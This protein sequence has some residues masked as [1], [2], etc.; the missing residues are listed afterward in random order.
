MAALESFNTKYYT[1]SDKW[2]HANMAI[3]GIM[4]YKQEPGESAEVETT[5]QRVLYGTK[6][7]FEDNSVDVVVIPTGV[8]MTYLSEVADVPTK[9]AH[10]MMYL[11]NEIHRILKPNGKLLTSNMVFLLGSMEKAL[12]ASKFGADDIGLLLNN[13][14]D[15]NSKPANPED[16]NFVT[17]GKWLWWSYIP[18]KITI[19]TKKVAIAEAINLENA[20]GAGAGAGVVSPIAPADSGAIDDTSSPDAAIFCDEEDSKIQYWFPE[21]RH[22]RLVE[23]LIAVTLL[24]WVGYVILT[25]QCLRYLELPYFLPYDEQMAALFISNANIV[26]F[27]LYIICA[28]M[29][30]VART[31]ESQVRKLG[32]GTTSAEITA[33]LCARVRSAYYDEMFDVAL[34]LTLNSGLGWLPYFLFDMLLVKAFGV[35]DKTVTNLNTVLS[36]V[37]TVFFI[38]CAGYLARWYSKIKTRQSKEQDQQTESDARQSMA[39]KKTVDDRDW[40]SPQESTSK[41]H[42]DIAPAH[43]DSGSNGG[44]RTGSKTQSRRASRESIGISGALIGRESAASEIV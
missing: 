32:P 12:R 21:G 34:L 33:I 17:L 30:T 44:S 16:S 2:V 6:M 42:F 39:V 40:R 5:I 15:K 36:V 29:R 20:A 27:V 22:W 37:I 26:P 7:G 35:A 31:A 4:P 38:S 25:W 43:E 19:A 1:E 14:D 8:V 23:A 13:Q 3:E 11:L 18:A 41:Q 28:R 10:R 9:H 24:A